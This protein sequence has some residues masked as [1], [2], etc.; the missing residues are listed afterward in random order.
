MSTDPPIRLDSTVVRNANHVSGDVDGALVLLGIDQGRYY[1][2]EEVAR[3]IWELLERPRVASALVDLLMAEFDVSR[4]EC[5][6]DV[7]DFLEELRAERLVQVQPEG[8]SA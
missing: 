1:H 6:A 4:P 8:A 3:R 2:L 7:L 5:E